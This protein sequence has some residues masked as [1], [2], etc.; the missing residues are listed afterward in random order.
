MNHLTLAKLSQASY[1]GVKPIKK[2]GFNRVQKF[3]SGRTGTKAYLAINDDAKEAVLVFRGTE[4]DGKDIL[5]DLMFSKEEYEG[6]RIH[7]GFLR[8]YKSVQRHID[9]RV[10]ELPKDYTLYATGHSLGGALTCLYSLY[11]SVQPDEV[12][13]FGQPRV[14]D[15]S[16]A[17]ELSGMFYTR[18]VYHADVVPR[19]PKIGYR[20]SPDL[21]YISRLGGKIYN[22]SGFGMFVDR[23]F[24][25]TKRYTSH[26]IQ[27]YVDALEHNDYSL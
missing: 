23:I 6:S 15:K 18:Y 27:N 4:K 21:L 13:T 17:Q 14:G 1:V 8:A 26:R 3:R 5:T 20:H 2:L 25:F 16:F 12:V 11:G 9:K 22:P 24:S 19:V 10:T 7:K